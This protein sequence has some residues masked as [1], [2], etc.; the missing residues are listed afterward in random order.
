MK[1]FNEKTVQ[2]AKSGDKTAFCDLYSL[3]AQDMYNFAFFYMGNKYDA[4]DAVQNAV[5]IAFRSL[6][7]LRKNSAFKSWLFKILSNCCKEMLNRRTSRENYIPLEDIEF[8][9]ED[10]KSEKKR[11]YIELYSAIECLS[12]TDRNIILLSVIGKYKSDEIAKIINMKPATVRSRLSRAM[13]KLR[14]TLD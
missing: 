4:E 7:S 11:K 13:E 2:L 14:N 10:E 5:I 1:S 12:E 9:A 8:S 6:K 3:Y